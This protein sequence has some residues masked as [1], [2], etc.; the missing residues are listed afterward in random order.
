MPFYRFQVEVPLPRPCVMAQIRSLVRERRSVR[1]W[2]SEL[3]KPRDSPLPPFIGSANEDSFRMVQRAT[4]G[5][6]RFLPQVRGYVLPTPTGTQI[7]ITMLIRPV[8][9]VF[10]TLWLGLLG[11]VAFVA[12]S[13]PLASAIFLFGVAF[14]FGGFFSEAFRAKRILTDAFSDSEITPQ[15]STSR[16]P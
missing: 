14:V 11:T 16:A 12:A 2:F 6:P 7:N 15:T 3:R 8:D 9:A 10:M 1:Q 4:G 13:I 5:K